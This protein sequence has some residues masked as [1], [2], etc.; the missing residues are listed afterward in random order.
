MPSHQAHATTPFADLTPDRVLDAVQDLGFDVDGRLLQLNS[1]ENRV[2]QIGLDDGSSV[3]AKFYRPGRWSND[4]ILEEHQF[5]KELEHDEIPI[6]APLAL[7]PKGHMSVVGSF[8]TLGIRD[9]LRISVSLRKGGRSPELEDAQTLTWIG[10]FLARIHQVGERQPF[11]YR[12]CVSPTTMGLAARTWLVSSEMIPVDQL[13]GW[14]QASKQALELVTQCFDRAG[15]IQFKRIHGDCHVGNILWTPEGPHFVD[16]DDA[17]MG[18]AIQDFWM[19]LSGDMAQRQSQ[20][21][22]LL[23][24]YE[25]LLEFDWREAQLIEALRTLRMIHHSAWIAKRW[26]DP[27][28]PAAFSWFGQPTY[29]QEQTDLLRQQ[30]EMLS[31][32]LDQGAAYP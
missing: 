31:E 2:F 8:S 1:Y 10:R 4:Q 23:D 15:D 27:A 28:F 25:T 6:V 9:E 7:S 12:D 24:G 29:W 19:L 30:S 32:V 16:L 18:P 22:A 21:F 3:I 5:A 26:H 17:C 14:Q 11:R 13:S 20:L